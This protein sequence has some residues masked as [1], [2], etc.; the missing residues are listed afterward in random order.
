MHADQGFILPHEWFAYLYKSFHGLF[1]K[2]LMGTN[3]DAESKRT[4]MP[5][6]GTIKE[7]EPKRCAL[8]PSMP[9]YKTIPRWIRGDGVPCTKQV[10][11]L[12]LPAHF[13]S[14]NIHVAAFIVSDYSHYHSH[15]CNHSWRHSLNHKRQEERPL[16][17]LLQS[18]SS[19]PSC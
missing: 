8:R 13:E 18:K 6:W 7:H 1:Y 12:G 2:L 17:P 10:D 11:E 16:Q 9:K 4:V 5:F 3:G 19:A 15:R 14:D